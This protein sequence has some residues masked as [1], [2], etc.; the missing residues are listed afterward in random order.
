MAGSPRLVFLKGLVIVLGVLI[1]VLA[2]ILIGELLRRAFLADTPEQRESVAPLRSIAP[3]LPEGARLADMVAT[4]NYVVVHVVL[5]DGETRL[6]VLDPA[7]VADHPRA[8]SDEDPNDA[9][10]PLA[11]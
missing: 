7:A 8:P 9:L 2:T 4:S 1:L 11:R 6:F 3:D 5:Q 10:Q